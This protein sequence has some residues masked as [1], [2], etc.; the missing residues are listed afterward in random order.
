[1]NCHLFQ[2]LKPVWIEIQKQEYLDAQMTN[3][4]K[5]YF[6]KYKLTLQLTL[7]AIF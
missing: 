4:E 2:R 1:M 6:S 3:H 7:K 5:F